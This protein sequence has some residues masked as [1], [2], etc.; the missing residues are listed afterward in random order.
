MVSKP[1]SGLPSC[2]GGKREKGYQRKI[3]ITIREW[4]PRKRSVSLKLSKYHNPFSPAETK[5]H[6]DGKLFLG[7]VRKGVTPEGRIPWTCP[8]VWGRTE[9]VGFETKTS[10][11]M[12]HIYRARQR[13]P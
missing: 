3:N 2:C 5:Q 6:E 10:L 4:E 1:V 12:S 11:L 9:V 7:Y 8:S 13:V